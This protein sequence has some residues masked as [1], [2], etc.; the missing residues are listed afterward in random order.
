[1][2]WSILCAKL[3]GTIYNYFINNM[4]AM[5]NRELKSY[6]SLFHSL[7]S[8]KWTML[9]LECKLHIMGLGRLSRA[10]AMWSIV[11]WLQSFIFFKRIG[12]RVHLSFDMAEWEVVAMILLDVNVR[13][14]AWSTH[15][16]YYISGIS[17]LNFTWKLT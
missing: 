15:S 13:C 14:G 5:K 17:F 7:F 12:W 9:A 16:Q 8:S 10:S 3:H 4:A 6:F 1:M 11:S 2:L